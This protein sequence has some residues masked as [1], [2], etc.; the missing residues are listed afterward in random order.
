M[1]VTRAMGNLFG[2]DLNLFSSQ[3]EFSSNILKLK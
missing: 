1:L 3:A 2:L